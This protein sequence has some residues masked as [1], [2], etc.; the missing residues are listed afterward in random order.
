VRKEL[1]DALERLDQ[2]Y[3]ERQQFLSN[4]AHDLKTPISVMLTQSQVMEPE[5]S[6]LDEFRD[7]RASMVEELLRLRGIIEGILTL[8]RAEQGEGMLRRKSMKVD[9]LVTLCASRCRT[10]AAANNV[11]IETRALGSSDELNGDVDLLATMLDNIVRNAIRFSPAGGTII[12][13]AEREEGNVRLG[14][15]D[16]GAGIPE[17]YID[18]IFD[19]FVQVPDVSRRGRGTGLGL[20]IAKAVCEAHGGSIAVANLDR[21][22]VFTVTLPL[23]V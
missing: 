20:A 11:T 19:R 15:R 7:Y 2:G 13:R 8:S 14:V 9:D 22:C 17:D 3:R 4:V 21:G 5:Q 10:L 1:N 18:K 12:M 6:S 23:I 16:F